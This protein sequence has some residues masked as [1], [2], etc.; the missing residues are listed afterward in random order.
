MN[1][2]E[3]DPRPEPT[4]T[5]PEDFAV[6]VQSLVAHVKEKTKPLDACA[7][8]YAHIK[9]NLAVAHPGLDLDQFIHPKCLSVLHALPV[10]PKR[11]KS[12]RLREQQRAKL[13][14]QWKIDE[15]SLNRTFDGSISTDFLL[16]LNTMASRCDFATAEPL[17]QK[18]RQDRRARVGGYKRWQG[19]KADATWQPLDVQ[20]AMKA[21][22]LQY[23]AKETKSGK[24]VRDESS[25]LCSHRSVTA[26]RNPK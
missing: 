12:D 11:K 7:K 22:G 8:D 15:A 6:A 23:P 10:T 17:L 9:Q 2:A 1:E 16:A 26:A 13:C 4:A 20:N 14:G 25:C 19:S 18:A 24:K 5:L 21:S 3:L